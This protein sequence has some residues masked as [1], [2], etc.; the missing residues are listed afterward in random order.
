MAENDQKDEGAAA[1]G[2]ED[3]EVKDSEAA[4]LKDRLLRMAAEFDNYKKRVAKDIDNSKDLGRADVISKLLPTL[5]EFELAM[6]SMG[7]ED[8]NHKGIA[9]IY[10]NLIST[11]KG[12]GLREI[13]AKGKADPYRHEIVMAQKSDTEDGTII[14][15]V[16]KGYMLNEIMIRPAS[17]I[18]SQNDA[19]KQEQKSG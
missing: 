7:K 12:F 19:E 3:A 8:E 1:P 2:K 18:I 14:G 13:D 10:S 16:R 4:E 5:D 11:L 9:L 6:A 17:V 15:V